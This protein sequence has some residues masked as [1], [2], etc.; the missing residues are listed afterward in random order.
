MR[1][2]P[3][4]ASCARIALPAGIPPELGYMPL[5]SSAPIADGREGSGGLKL[6]AAG[7]VLKVDLAGLQVVGLKWLVSVEEE[8]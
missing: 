4:H 5:A 3:Y 6:M 8:K 2:S 1:V 7:S